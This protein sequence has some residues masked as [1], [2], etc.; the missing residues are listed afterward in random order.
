MRLPDRIYNIFKWLL[1]I[2]V[3]A[4]ITLFTLLATTWA[5][6]IPT[7]AIVATISGVSTFIGVIIGISNKTY[8]N[9]TDDINNKG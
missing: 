1:I 6:D 5:W 7:E 2:V 9:Q 8:Y 4:F 3:P